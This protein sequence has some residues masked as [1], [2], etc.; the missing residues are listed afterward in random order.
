MR[1]LRVPSSPKS[2]VNLRSLLLSSFLTQLMIFPTLRSILSKSEKGITCFIYLFYQIN[3]NKSSI[4]VFVFFMVSGGNS[5][6][7]GYLMF[8]KKSLLGFRFFFIAL[9]ILFSFK[10]ITSMGYDI[11]KVCIPNLDLKSMTAGFLKKIR[12]NSSLFKLLAWIAFSE[13]IVF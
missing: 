7:Y 4:D 12:P 8:Q 5:I 13:I 11:K 1:I 6:T 10:I 3:S 2:T 9:T